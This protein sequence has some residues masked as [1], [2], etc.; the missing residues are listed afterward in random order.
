M[1]KAAQEVHT[2]MGGSATPIKPRH[3][4]SLSLVGVKTE[5]FAAK[6]AAY[7]QKWAL[8]KEIASLL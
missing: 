5:Q 8:I 4:P 7:L 2:C 6:V 1:H 3:G